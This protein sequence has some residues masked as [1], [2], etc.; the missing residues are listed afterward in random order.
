MTCP[1]CQAEVPAAS[2][3]CP[4]C[5]AS[6]TARAQTVSSG[7]AGAAPALQPTVQSAG[8]LSPNAAAA[9][10]Y[11]TIIP[12]II[13]LVIEPYNRIKLVRFHAVQCIGLT[14]VAIAVSLIAA[15]IPVVGWL[16]QPFISL[17]F[18]IVWI[19]CILKA[20]KGEFFKLPVIG[21]F[22]EKQANA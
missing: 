13:F 5:G 2:V 6:T 18:L 15:L 22:A 17:A 16:A 9:I 1:S 7:A 20:S 14:I 10:A 8:G 11:V 3:F 21:D 12:A 4:Q 19:M